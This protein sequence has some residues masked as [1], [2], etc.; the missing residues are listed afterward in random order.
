[1][2]LNPPLPRIANP[3]AWSVSSLVR[4]SLDRPRPHTVSRP[5]AAKESHSSSHRRSRKVSRRTPPPSSHTR[6]MRWLTKA[7]STSWRMPGRDVDGT[8]VAG[9]ATRRAR[10]LGSTRLAG[11][12]VAATVTG[13]VPVGDEATGDGLGRCA[14][15]S[16]RAAGSGAA[17][18]LAATARSFSSASWAAAWMPALCRFHQTSA[19]F[20]ITCIRSVASAGGGRTLNTCSL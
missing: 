15:R 17:R 4:T 1:M 7:A 8:R 19:A 3:A 6:A 5:R 2:E 16:V 18:F 20:E 11:G 10:D 9:S 14:G 13:V 12:G